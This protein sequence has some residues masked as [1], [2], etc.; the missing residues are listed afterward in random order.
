MSQ[1]KKSNARKLDAEEQ[2]LLSS[3]E[4]NEWRTVKNVGKEQKHAREA[5]AKTLTKDVRINIRLSSVDILHIK[6][7]AAYEEVLYQTLIASVL[8]KYAAGHL[9][10]S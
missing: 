6:Q 5:T 7:K 1:N 10:N 9:H 4:N 3:F 8:H 2:E